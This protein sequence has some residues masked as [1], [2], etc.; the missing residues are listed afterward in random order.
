M[1]KTMLYLPEIQHERLTRLA[2]ETGT[3]M[4]QLVRDAIEQYLTHCRRPVRARFVGSG[5]G[6]RG[7]RASEHVDEIL[8]KMSR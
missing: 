3:S 1:K 6:P 5:A 7:G 8:G 4:A 2:A